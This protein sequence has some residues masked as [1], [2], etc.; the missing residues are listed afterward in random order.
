MMEKNKKC[1]Y[2]GEEILVVAKKCKYC[3]EWLDK[4]SVSKQIEC[5]ICAEQIDATAVVCPFC[6]EPI[7]P[8]STSSYEQSK[9]K[10]SAPISTPIQATTTVSSR[11]FISETDKK[12]PASESFF[13]TYFWNVITQNYA[14]FKGSMGRKAYWMYVL[15]Y[16]ALIMLVSAGLMLCNVILGTIAYMGLC[17]V[18]LLPTLSAAIRRLHDIGKSGW[19]VLICMIPFVG[20]IWLLILLCKKGKSES[21]CAK[22]QLPDTI[23][24]GIVSMILGIGIIL[25]A[26]NGEKYYVYK[27]SEWTGN[28]DFSWFYAVASNNQKDMEPSDYI[29]HYGTQLIVAAKEPF[30]KVHKIISGEDIA[31]K[32]PDV[33]PDLNYEIFPSSVDPNLLYFN[34]WNN[35]MEFPSCGKV[36]CKTGEFDLFNGTIIGMI[37]DG[38]LDG[39]YMKVE[40]NGVKIYPQSDI[41]QSAAPYN[42]FNINQYWRGH[43]NEELILNKAFAKQVIAWIE[44]S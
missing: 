16:M 2:C 4:E 27:D 11:P 43:S 20:S 42:V 32:D 7:N 24:T 30:G 18:L 6:H 8:N 10:L 37:S 14:D 40:S 33:S 12:E 26:I 25:S 21:P 28:C 9:P 5:P 39:Y 13:K 38:S 41:G 3:G 23:H 31:T 1:P 15:I 34:Y 19:M 36:Y 17:L 35:G 29:D 22:W 44:N